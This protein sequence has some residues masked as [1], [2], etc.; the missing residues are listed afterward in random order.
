MSN[1]IDV[2]RKLGIVRTGT[3]SW[4]GKAKNRK[5]EM[6]MNDVQNSKKDLVR[7]TEGSDSA[8]YVK[9]LMGLS[10]ILAAVILLLFVSTGSMNVWFFL[11]LIVWPSFLFYLYRMLKT[12]KFK[13]RKAIGL[14]T[15]IAACSFFSLAGLSTVTK[16]VVNY[17]T[18]TNPTDLVDMS[19]DLENTL[20]MEDVSVTEASGGI[21]EIRTKAPANVSTRAILLTVAYIFSYVQPALPEKIATIRVILTMNGFDALVF[22][23]DRADLQE[24]MAGKISETD[25]VAKIRTSNL[26]K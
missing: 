25:Y 10:L 21:I 18:I 7:N 1:F 19:I 3:S 20:K 4:S 15:L 13:L 26:R 23:T 9:L 22:E 11:N 12:K 16:D 5:I 17:D 24:Y 8:L 2:L 14:L 6:I